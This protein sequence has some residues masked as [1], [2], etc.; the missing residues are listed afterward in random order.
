MTSPNE[1]KTQTMAFVCLILHDSSLEAMEKLLIEKT[2]QYKSYFYNSAL[3]INIAEV[4]SIPEISEIESLTNKY[5]FRLIGFSGVNNRNDI[6]GRIFNA[7]YPVF[8]EAGAKDLAVNAQAAAPQVQTKE[9]IKEVIKEV[10]VKVPA[11]AP[12]LKENTMYVARSLHSGESIYAKGQSLLIIGDVP[13]GS[14]VKADYNIQIEGRLYGRACS[15]QCGANIESHITC[16]DFDPELV[17]VTGIYKYGDSFP[18]E[19]YHKGVHIYCKDDNMKY[20]VIGSTPR[21][22]D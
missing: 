1:L 18:E 6:K 3:M 8:N 10:V 21:A 19:Y 5:N 20:E 16:N 2:N 9:V 17:S 13:R 7:G 12:A 11:E 4:E 15:G 14:E 22:L